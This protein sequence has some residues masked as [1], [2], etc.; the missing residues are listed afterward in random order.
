MSLDDA[1]ATGYRGLGFLTW[2]C[3]VQA[4]RGRVY[5]KEAATLAD[6]CFGVNAYQS[7]RNEADRAQSF[8][9]IARR[10]YEMC[11]S[12]LRGDHDRAFR[13]QLA[14]AGCLERAR[15]LLGGREL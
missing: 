14:A 2:R 6:R 9:E 1:V 4:S 3:S 11:L 10:E 5:A 12:G 13:A 15:N 8:A 7:I